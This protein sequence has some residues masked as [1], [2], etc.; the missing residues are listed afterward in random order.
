MQVVFRVSVLLLLIATVASAAVPCPPPGI[1]VNISAVVVPTGNNVHPSPYACDVRDSKTLQPI[2]PCG[3]PF[4]LNVGNGTGADTPAIAATVVETS[5][6][7]FWQFGLPTLGMSMIQAV[8]F[9]PTLEGNLHT[10]L[11]FGSGGYPTNLGPVTLAPNTCKTANL[12]SH[13][14][15]FCFWGVHSA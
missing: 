15:K 6:Q 10:Q 12:P 5:A 13:I 11:F 4:L 1:V 14:A 2:A 7:S 3:V 9:V 8:A